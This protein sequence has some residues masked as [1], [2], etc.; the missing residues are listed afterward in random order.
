MKYLQILNATLMAVG[1]TLSVVLGV[2]CLLF[3]IYWDRSASLRAQ[4]PYLVDM[5]GTFFLLG[6][7]ASLSFTA[8]SMSAR[9]DSF[10]TIS[11]W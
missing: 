6:G 4:T 8:R 9:A 5:M 2:V 3:W 11:K 1:A 7:A 10:D